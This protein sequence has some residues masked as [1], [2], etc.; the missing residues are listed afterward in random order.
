ME[1]WNNRAGEYENVVGDS[2]E[3]NRDRDRDMDRETTCRGG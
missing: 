1:S 3:R 2:V